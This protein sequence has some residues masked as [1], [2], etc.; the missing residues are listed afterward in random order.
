[1]KAQKQK[2]AARV[3][4]IF[5]SV[6]MLGSGLTLIVSLIVEMLAH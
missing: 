2:L 3:M 1:M 6:L 5:L 4:A